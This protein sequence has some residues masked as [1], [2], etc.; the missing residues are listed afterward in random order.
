MH[1]FQDRS[2]I[3]TTKKYVEEEGLVS[4]EKQSSNL[5]AAS[6]FSLCYEIK[7]RLRGHPQAGTLFP[8]ACTSPTETKFLWSFSPSLCLLSTYAHH[9]DQSGLPSQSTH[10]LFPLCSFCHWS[11]VLSTLYLQ[12]RNHIPQGPSFNSLALY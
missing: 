2:L 1:E 7:P 8:L 12:Y 11:P 3:S 10:L 5:G 4:K 6:C 9:Q